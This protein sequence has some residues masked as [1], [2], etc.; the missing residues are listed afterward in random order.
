M[1]SQTVLNM[2]N[3]IS[4]AGSSNGGNDGSGI[5]FRCLFLGGQ[6]FTSR[7][8]NDEVLVS[9]EGSTCSIFQ[10]LDLHCPQPSVSSNSSTSHSHAVTTSG[11]DLIAIH[12]LHTSHH[13]TFGDLCSVVEWTR[14]YSLHMPTAFIYIFF[15]PFLSSTNILFHCGQGHTH[16]DGKFKFEVSVFLHLA[17]SAY[18]IRNA[19]HASPAGHTRKPLTAIVISML[20]LVLKRPFNLTQKTLKQ[21]LVRLSWLLFFV[22]VFRKSCLPIVNSRFSVFL[23][24]R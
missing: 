13:Y 10:N 16:R 1:K 23:D 3:R 9:E 4:V 8:N 2:K 5:V 15:P 6:C 22:F 19:A 14:F 21:I 7:K 24:A 18:L 11:N 12:D 17:L 20:I